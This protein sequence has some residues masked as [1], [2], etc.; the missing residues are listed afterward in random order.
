MDPNRIGIQRIQLRQRLLGQF[1]VHLA[2][3]I[4]NFLILRLALR[5]LPQVVRRALEFP[6]FD[7]VI[8]QKQFGVVV[9]GI[10]AQGRLKTPASCGVVA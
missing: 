1:H 5:K 10:C 2:Q 3:Q 6:E 4:P 8:C 9:F 7:Q